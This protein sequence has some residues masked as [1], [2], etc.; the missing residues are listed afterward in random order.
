MKR[1]FCIV[2]FIIPLACFGQIN[3]QNISLKHPDSSI[4]YIGEQNYIKISGLDQKDKIEISSSTGSINVSDDGLISIK[5]T[6]A[7]ISD[8]LVLYQNKKAIF[9]KVFVVR[10]LPKAIAQLGYVNKEITTVNQILL[11]T[12]LYVV[13]PKCDFKHS[14][15]IMGFE[16]SLFKPN[17]TLKE[18]FEYIS[19]GELNLKQIEAI[20]KLK[21]GDILLFDNIKATCPDCAVLSLDPIKIT[22]K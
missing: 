16:L 10:T 15:S 20:K 13:L 4:L 12:K 14:L 21:S 11:N 5:V 3:I 9:K 19:E 8:T 7:N 22:I 2:I 6:K 1:L 17:N 18:L